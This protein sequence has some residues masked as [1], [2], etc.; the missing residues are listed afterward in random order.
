MLYHQISGIS[1]Q[2]RNRNLSNFC[3]CITEKCQWLS[4]L[5]TWG[6]VTAV[7]NFYPILVLDSVPFLDRITVMSYSGQYWGISTK[8]CLLSAIPNPIQTSRLLRTINTLNPSSLVGST[9]WIPAWWYAL[10]HDFSK[11]EVLLVTSSSSPRLA[12]LSYNQ[13][14]LKLSKFYLS[15]S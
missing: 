12:F 4:L 13:T 2:D 9:S 3:T 8:S 14:S 11:L 15:D 5:L 7:C 6:Y 1:I 10:C